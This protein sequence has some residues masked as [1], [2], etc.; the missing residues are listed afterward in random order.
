MSSW[1]ISREALFTSYMSSVSYDGPRDQHS[2]ENAR[3]HWL[4]LQWEHFLC[5]VDQLLVNCVWMG[6]SNQWLLIFAYLLKLT[7]QERDFSFRSA[8][9]GELQGRLEVA[10]WGQSWRYQRKDFTLRIKELLLNT[11][12]CTTYSQSRW[13]SSTYLLILIQCQ[14]KL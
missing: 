7:L 5:S 10:H 9:F 1:K 13:Q 11:T 14:K 2:M 4:H 8:C 12:P 6:K 3:R